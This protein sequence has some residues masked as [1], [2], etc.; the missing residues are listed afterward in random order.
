M[1]RPTNNIPKRSRRMVAAYEALG[2]DVA[3]VESDG[4]I[5][6]RW[7]GTRNRRREPDFHPL[8]QTILI[9]E[10]VSM[11]NRCVGDQSQ[12][13]RRMGMPIING[14]A[15]SN[16]HRGKAVFRKLGEPTPRE[17]LHPGSK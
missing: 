11:L 4:I 14:R 12:F 10:G 5:T 6:M 7:D 8:H 17:G 2:Y 15:L 13:H 3:R 1:T 9:R 16:I